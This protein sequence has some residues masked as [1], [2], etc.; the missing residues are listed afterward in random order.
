MVA[1]GMI[2]AIEQKESSRYNEI[3]MAVSFYQTGGRK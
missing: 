3:R 2:Y 1:F